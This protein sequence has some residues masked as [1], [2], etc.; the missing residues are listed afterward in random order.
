DPIA[1]IPLA[2]IP[3]LPSST[4]AG[5]RGI[6]TLG[7]WAGKPVLVSAGRLHYYEGH[8]WEVV[9][10]P[11]R[12]AASLGARQA[13]LTNAAGGIREDL[14]PGSLMP[15]RDHLEWNR[16]NPWREP[17]SPPPY[18]R[19]LLDLV[20]RA[21]A[22]VGLTLVPGVYASVTGPTYET[23][24]EIRALRS[25]GA[26]AVGMSTTREALAGVAS[27]MECAAISLVTNRGAGLTGERLSHEEV[28]T[29][30]MASAYR[31]AALIE[32]VHRL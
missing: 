20:A 7:R 23:P 3:G 6:W 16:P 32:Q 29:I 31:L 13:I 14:G 4:V 2:A 28:S 27:G 5:H 8:L 25:A 9:T 10:R 19:R 15:L 12:L 26:D 30:G 17:K 22:D 21:G 1:S 11:I 24:A 18:S